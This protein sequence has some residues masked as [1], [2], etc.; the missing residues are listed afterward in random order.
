M[1]F[2]DCLLTN[3]I[4]F[5]LVEVKAHTDWSVLHSPHDPIRCV[6][7]SER[8]LFRDMIVK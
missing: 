4:L 5:N 6:P 8:T 7:E 3:F 2:L 1:V